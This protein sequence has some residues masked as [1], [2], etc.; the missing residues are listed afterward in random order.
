MRLTADDIR[1]WLQRSHDIPNV[2]TEA[3][4]LFRTHL[5]QCARVVEA[6]EAVVEHPSPANLSAL[7]SAL[8]GG[9]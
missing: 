6:A 1:Y 7:A 5:E 2:G 9:E 3:Y 8:D 4:A